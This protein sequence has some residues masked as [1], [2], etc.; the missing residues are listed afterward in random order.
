M[1][2]LKISSYIILCAPVPYLNFREHY[3]FTD[4]AISWFLSTAI[5]ISYLFFSYNISYADHSGPFHLTK[6]K[7]SDRNGRFP[8]EIETQIR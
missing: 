1:S 2:S 8:I 3:G 6:P 5:L 4:F 7:S